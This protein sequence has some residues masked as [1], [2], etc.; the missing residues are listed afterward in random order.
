VN[1]SYLKAYFIGATLF[2]LSAASL[3]D[4]AKE[5]NM[6]TCIAIL[7]ATLGEGGVDSPAFKE[8]KI[9]FTK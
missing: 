4:T 6:E 1:S 3:A 5:T 9:L 7:E 8:V 2:F